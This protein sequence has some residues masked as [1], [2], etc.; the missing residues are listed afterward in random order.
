MADENLLPRRKPAARDKTYIYCTLDI[1]VVSKV[2]CE[3]VGINLWPVSPIPGKTG[4]DE[5]IG[6]TRIV[7]KV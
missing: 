2:R 7:K 5:D 6:V 3:V 4:E 1:I